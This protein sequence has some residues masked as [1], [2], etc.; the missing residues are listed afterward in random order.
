ML[1]NN[2]NHITKLKLLKQPTS[3]I[4]MNTK[5][6]QMREDSNE[7]MPM[8]TFGLIRLI[9]KNIDWKKGK[10]PLSTTLQ[11]LMLEALAYAE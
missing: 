2:L 3:H 8:L 4:K 7:S 6:K 11:N 9:I 5:I 1:Q 10:A